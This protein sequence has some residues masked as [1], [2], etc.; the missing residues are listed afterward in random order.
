MTTVEL[1]QAELVGSPQSSLAGKNW[2]KEMDPV[3]QVEQSLHVQR[4]TSSWV[5][6]LS[7][8]MLKLICELG[9]TVAFAFQNETAPAHPGVTWLASNE[10]ACCGYAEVVLIDSNTPEYDHDCHPAPNCPF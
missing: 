5:L 1:V 6:A 2:A 3:A 8:R 10:Y 9:H 7:E 4:N